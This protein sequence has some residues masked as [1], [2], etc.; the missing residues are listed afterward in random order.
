VWCGSGETL[1]NGREV[2][3]VLEADAEGDVDKGKPGIA[4]QFLCALDS[5][6]QDEVMWASARRHSELCGEVHSGLACSIR[7]IGK[8]DPR[9]KM[10][11]DVVDDP[12][13]APLWK[14]R[15]ATAAVRQISIAAH[16]KE[17]REDGQAEC[18]DIERDEAF[19]HT[20][21][22]D[23]RMEKALDGGI[24]HDTRIN[25]Q[26]LVRSD[27]VLQAFAENI[28]HYVKLGGILSLERH[29]FQELAELFKLVRINCR[30]LRPPARY[31]NRD[32]HAV[33]QDLDQLTR[34]PHVRCRSGASS[35]GGELMNNSGTGVIQQR[36]HQHCFTPHGQ[37]LSKPPLFW[38]VHPFY[39]RCAEPRVGLG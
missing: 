19:L 20:V 37:R 13:Q 4:Q 16:A 10:R 35:D 30:W 15:Y 31:R 1:E 6:T 29:A 8:R 2:G 21:K 12:F 7:Q 26:D 3:L 9:S 18:F 36:W 14:G 25:D 5:P 28:T 39:V 22:S 32:F 23:K 24:P 34:R 33:E 27:F 11:I 17:L 38:V